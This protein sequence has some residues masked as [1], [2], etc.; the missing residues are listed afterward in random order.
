MKMLVYVPTIL[1]R[2]RVQSQI[3]ARIHT[4]FLREGIPFPEV[5]AG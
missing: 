4:A 2:T 1:D 5:R 3:R